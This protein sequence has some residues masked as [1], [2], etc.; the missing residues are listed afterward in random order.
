M[1]QPYLQDTQGAL[2]IFEP[3]TSYKQIANKTC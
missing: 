1:P 2:Q 3:E